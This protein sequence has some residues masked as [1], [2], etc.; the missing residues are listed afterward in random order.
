MGRI[1]QDSQEEPGKKKRITPGKILALVIGIIVVIY[2]TFSVRVFYNFIKIMITDPDAG[3]Q[4]VPAV[5]L[6]ED[7][8]ELYS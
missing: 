6:Y 7:A 5:M 4:D 2:M 8:W 1:K 3:K